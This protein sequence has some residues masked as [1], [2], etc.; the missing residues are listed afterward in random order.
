MIEGRST[1][2]A[3]VRFFLQGKRKEK[4]IHRATVEFRH[5]KFREI[6]EMKFN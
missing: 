3:E 2:G 6:F 5:N 1:H 4:K